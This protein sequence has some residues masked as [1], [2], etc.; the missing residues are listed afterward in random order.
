MSLFDAALRL[1]ALD[2]LAHIFSILVEN[3][4]VAA[5]SYN[6]SVVVEEQRKLGS[7]KPRNSIGERLREARLN[8]SPK[9]T[10]ID[11][12]ALLSAY[13]V[14]INQAAISKIESG[15][16]PVFDYELMG[17]GEALVIDVGWLVNEDKL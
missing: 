6:L 13:G 11:L 7:R 8:R 2:V 17:I 5:L 9:I 14:V 10:Q 4:T 16:R 12:S 15:D 1:P 3:I